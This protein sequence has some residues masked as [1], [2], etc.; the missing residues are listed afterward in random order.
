M[1]GERNFFRQKKVTA[2]Y[3]HNHTNIIKYAEDPKL[4]WDFRRRDDDVLIALM[5]PV[6]EIKK[7]LQKEAPDLIITN[8][9]ECGDSNN[10]DVQAESDENIVNNYNNE[11]E[12]T[13]YSVKDSTVQTERIVLD[14]E[15]GQLGLS[16]NDEVPRIQRKP[17]QQ[18]VSLDDFYLH[19]P[20]LI[21]SPEKGESSPL[22]SPRTAAPSDVDDSELGYT[23]VRSVTIIRHATR[24]PTEDTILEMKQI[25]PELQWMLKLA[26][27]A[28][29][30]RAR[31]KSR[32]PQNKCYTK[33]MKDWELYEDLKDDD[34]EMKALVEEG[35]REAFNLGK[36]FRIFYKYLL[37]EEFD[38][39][40]IMVKFTDSPR[41]KD[42]AFNVIKGIFEKL[43]PGDD[44]YEEVAG[45]RNILKYDSSCPGWKS[46]K[47]SVFT[48]HLTKSFL[49]SHYIQ[50]IAKDVAAACG[51]E[52]D[53]FDVDENLNKFIQ[54]RH[55]ERPIHIPSCP[56]N[57]EL[58]CPLDIFER[59]F[60]KFSYENCKYDEWCRM[61]NAPP[62]KDKSKKRFTVGK[63]RKLLR[64]E[65]DARK[66]AKID[67]K[68][69][70]N[71]KQKKDYRKIKSA[72]DVEFQK[73]LNEAN[74][75]DESEQQ[76]EEENFHRLDQFL[77]E[78]GD[79]FD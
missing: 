36:R 11:T 68:T 49:N 52:E 15:T 53:E 40:S 38:K 33:E 8:N 25:L 12:N 76:D 18:S 58:L 39:E 64:K 7:I 75:D 55:Q 54:V 27:G 26:A 20:R 59:G 14:P 71:K 2:L 29:T 77:A 1:I 34:V 42:T 35:K 23:L 62:Q 60:E 10:D 78:Y 16:V 31:R 22:P 32:L 67:E 21:Q 66:K 37:P 48:E 57:K 4:K 74:I 3:S 44:W 45:K 69:T 41:T 63:R 46:F 9:N 51:L 13:S 17:L 24:L 19:N 73:V 65:R 56:L 72:G 28:K 70:G 6:E 79:V 5:K 47:N 50:Q 43:P 30:K 61:G